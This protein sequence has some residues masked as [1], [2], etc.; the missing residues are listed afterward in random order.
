MVKH[1]FRKH[2]L[3][4]SLIAINSFIVVEEFARLYLT[5][6]KFVGLGWYWTAL[7]SLPCSLLWYLVIERFPS[8]FLCMIALVLV[9][10]F[11]WGIVGSALDRW[12][13][14]RNSSMKT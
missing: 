13:R 14:P 5:H 2:R 12:S 4:F 11:Q 3:A 6:P 10:A 9:G 7:L 1:T 8:D